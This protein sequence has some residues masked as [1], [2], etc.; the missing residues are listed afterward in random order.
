MMIARKKKIESFHWHLNILDLL[1]IVNMFFTKLGAAALLLAPVAL[2]AP[3]TV[4]CARCDE[5]ATG[6]ASLNGG[7]TGGKGGR[8]VTATTHADLVKYA[9]ME[10]PLII[11]VDGALT[12]EPRGFEI[13]IKSH[14]TI[15]GV[16]RNGAIVGGGFGIK[17]QKNI[18]LRNLEVRDTY[19]PED[20]NG[21]SKDWDGIQV[22][23]GVNIWIDH[24]KVTILNLQNINLTY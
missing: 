6:F 11:R 15:I 2:A 19:I 24:C 8:I 9:A 20:Y 23:T 22:D 5:V 1:P 10:E 7:T 14:K 13:P 12:S 18:I 3:T 16:G 17:N 21:K 4:S